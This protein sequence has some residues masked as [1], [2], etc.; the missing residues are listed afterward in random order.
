[1][2]N[3]PREKCGVCDKCIYLHHTILVCAADGRSYHAKCLK[4]DPDTACEVQL[5]SDWFCPLCLENI[6]PFFNLLVSNDKLII[7]KCKSCLK[8]ISQSKHVTSHCT[9]CDDK[10]HV[11]CL[12][13]Q[14]CKP[15]NTH[16]NSE[17]NP[18]ICSK[19]FDPYLLDLE[20]D[21]NHDFFFDDDIDDSFNTVQIAKNI[22]KNCVYHNSNSLPLTKLCH[23][24]FYCNNIDSS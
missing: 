11:A 10:C 3:I 18:I 23:T 22:L 6:F 2:K 9:I 24:T 16:I 13:L 19:H 5:L 7:E 12:E 17:S 4:I 15:C 8:L 1:M 21:D 20:E 14:L